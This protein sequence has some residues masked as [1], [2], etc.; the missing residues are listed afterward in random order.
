MPIRSLSGYVGNVKIRARRFVHI[1]ETTA[2]RSGRWPNYLAAGLL[3]SIY[4]HPISIMLKIVCEAR[5]ASGTESPKPAT[6]TAMSTPTIAVKVVLVLISEKD[7]LASISG[8][9]S[10]A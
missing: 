6:L 8:F 3:L 4:G 5:K 2:A 7:C 1:A 10:H 9:L